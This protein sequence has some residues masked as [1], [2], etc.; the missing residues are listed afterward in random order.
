MTSIED[1]TSDNQ[2]GPGGW[3]KRQNAGLWFGLAFL[4]FS[5]L[6][7]RMSFDLAYMSKLGAGPGMYPRWLCGISIVVAL[8]YIWQ[9]CTTQV[10]RVGDRF[11]GRREL[12]NVA[13]IFV[14]CVVFLLLLN[15]VGFLVAGSALMFIAFWRNY[16]LW[17]AI[18]LSITITVITWVVFKIFFSVPL[19]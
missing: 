18:V 14:S 16:A 13:T 8:A 6:F 3:I 11:P 12:T 15:H 17:K 19:P 1:R 2:G 5:V 4:A 9:S 7:F 10:F